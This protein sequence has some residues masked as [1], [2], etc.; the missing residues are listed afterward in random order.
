MTQNY[1]DTD[2]RFWDSIKKAAAECGDINDATFRVWKSRGHIPK[3][4][5]ASLYLQLKD[6]PDEI[7]LAVLQARSSITPVHPESR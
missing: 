3:S 6:T 4:R 2:E 5:V 7:P 1:T